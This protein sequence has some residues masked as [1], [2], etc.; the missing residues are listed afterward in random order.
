MIAASDASNLLCPLAR[1]FGA[2]NQTGCRGADCAVWRWVP[3]T[4]AHPGW[5]KAVQAKAEELGEKAPFIRS[6]KWVA[7]NKIELGLVP[8]HG[9][10]GMGGQP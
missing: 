8:T 3:V 2:N 10:C 6:S 7:E 1:T 9:Y 5:V 4:T